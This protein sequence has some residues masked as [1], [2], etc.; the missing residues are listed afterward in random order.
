M[1]LSDV[2]VLRSSEYACAPIVADRIQKGGPDDGPRR[3][4]IA[5]RSPCPVACDV[6]GGNF[7]LAVIL[8]VSS[9]PSKHTVSCLQHRGWLFLHLHVAGFFTMCDN[10]SC[11]GEACISLSSFFSFLFVEITISSGLRAYLDGIWASSH[12]YCLKVWHLCYTLQSHRSTS[13]FYQHVDQESDDACEMLSG[14]QD[15]ICRH[16]RTLPQ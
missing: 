15:S 14:V 11:G 6:V 2:S 7:T 5:P 16:S 13:I 9:F 4:Y 3:M 10:D 1:P 12:V 8:R